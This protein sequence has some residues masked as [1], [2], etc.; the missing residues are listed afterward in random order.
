MLL[1]S[2]LNTGGNLTVGVDQVVSNIFMS[3]DG[4]PRII[5]CTSTRI[6]FLTEMSA[7]GAYC[8]DDGSW[9]SETATYSPIYYDQNNTGYYVNPNG[10]TNLYSLVLSGGTYFQP[11]SWIQFNGAYGC[12]WPSNNDAHLV[13]TT[14]ASYSQIEIRGSRGGYGG[15]FDFYSGVNGFMYDGAGNGGVYR[16]ANGRWYFYHNLANNCTGF[17]TST[18]VSGWSIYVPAGVY[19]DSRIDA[20]L[21][22]D[23]S[24]TSFYLDPNATGTSL[25]VAGAIVAAGNVTAFS[26]IRV[27]DN[28]ETVPD[29]LTKLSA[30]RGVTYTRTDRDDKERRYAG[31]IAQEIEQVLPE[32]IFG[33]EN[34]KTVDYNA[35]I[36][37]LIEAV[38]EL[39]SEVETLKAA[40][41][42]K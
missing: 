28:I 40:I 32:A 25:N 7:W 15:I 4:G 24:N 16:E 6:G 23:V 13:A 33:D 38:K 26:D 8:A 2:D 31:V 34:I 10:T 5:H 14:N 39:K 21:F 41:R 20:S 27:K 11:N 1:L 18:T 30:I 17:G 42:S 22:Y 3:S 19:S 29:A 36:A 9:Y 37:L 12:Y 35:T